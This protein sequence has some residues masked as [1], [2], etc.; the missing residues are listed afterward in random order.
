MLHRRLVRD[1]EKL[2]QRSRAMVH[3]AIANITNTRL[4][5]ES[6][7]TWHTSSASFGCDSYFT[8]RCPLRAHR[9]NGQETDQSGIRRP[10]T[11]AS[12]PFLAGQRIWRVADGRSPCVTARLLG[13]A[14]SSRSVD[15]GCDDRVE[16]MP[17]PGREGRA[18]WPKAAK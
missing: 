12:S 17:N 14:Q 6:T 13:K 2:P 9:Q 11:G 1:Y 10:L 5:G 15:L 16:E 18:R 4:T 8:I 7:Q 3:W